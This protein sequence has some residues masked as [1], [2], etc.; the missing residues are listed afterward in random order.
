MTNNKVWQIIDDEMGQLV[1]C[2]DYQELSFGAEYNP[3]AR[4]D[5]S[6]EEERAEI[7]ANFNEIVDAH[8]S[9]VDRL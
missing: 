9:N 7:I 2:T 4:M 3:I 8:N 1:I 5:Y 6:Y